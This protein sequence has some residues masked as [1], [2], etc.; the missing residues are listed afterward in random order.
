MVEYL[1]SDTLFPPS[2]KEQAGRAGPAA[3]LPWAHGGAGA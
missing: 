3:L 2:G 1:S